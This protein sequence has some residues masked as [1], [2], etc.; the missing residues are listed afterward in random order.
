M[1]GENLH[2]EIRRVRLTEVYKDGMLGQIM[3]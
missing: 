2:N 1:E 3:E